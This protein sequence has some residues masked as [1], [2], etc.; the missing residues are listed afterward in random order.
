M[1]S[2]LRPL[3][4]EQ[5]F[6][7]DGAAADAAHTASAA[8]AHDSGPLLLPQAVE[9][10]TAPAARDGGKKEVVLVDTSLANYK[11]LEAG[12]RDGVG[13]VEFDGRADGLAQI[14]A[15]AAGQSG[16]DAIHILSHGNDGQLHLGSTTLTEASLSNAQVRAELTELGSALK[17]DGDVLL[18]GCD[19]AQ[20]PVGQNFIEHLSQ[21]S[22]A[23]VAASS[24]ATG[25]ALLGGDWALEYSAGTIETGTLIANDYQSL[26]ATTIFDFE[27]VLDGANGKAITQTIGSDT[28]VITAKD[29]RLLVSTENNLGFVS[30]A[31]GLLVATGEGGQ[32]PESM[33]TL[34]VSGGK[35]FDLSSFMLVPLY[36]DGSITLTTAKG[37]ETFTPTW[38]NNTWVFN[39]SNA[40]HPEYFLG[41]TSVTI[42]TPDNEGELAWAFDNIALSNISTFNTAP[43][44]SNLNGD[45]VAWAGVSNSVNLDVG[46]NAVFA[47][48]EFGAL[49][50]GNGNW[51]GASL[52]VQR[53]GTAVSADMLGFN[54]TGALF[55]VTGTTSGSLQSGGLTF[56][57]YTSIGGV[58]NIT[59]TSSGTAATTALVNDV[60]R[61]ISYRND[62]PAGDATMRYTLSDGASSTMAN[63]TVTS[64]TIYVT[65]TTDTA[66][67]NVSD[68][69]SF[70]EAVAIAAADVTGSQT[71]VFSSNFN[72]AVSLAGSLAINESLTLNADLAA[73]LTINGG[74]TITLGTGTT[75]GITNAAGAFTIAATLGGSG[76]LSKAGAGTLILSSV[77]NEA[78]MSGGITVN[79]GT[80]Q[81]S[82]DD[83]LSSGTL[84]LNGG[85][86][87][88]AASAMTIDNAIVLGAAGG[89][90]NVGGGGGSTAVVLSGVVSG[91]G[92]LTKNG[93][94]ILELS[95]NNT[96]AGATNIV[97]GTVIVSHANALG[98]TAGSTTVSGGA[99]VRLAGALTIAESFSITGSGKTVS[100]VNYGA[101]HLVSGN[102]TVSGTVTLTDAADISAASGATLTLSG[103]MS[104]AYALNKTDAGTLVLS[105]SGNEAG[106]S[107]GTTITAGTLSIAA[108]DHLSSGTITLNGGTLAITGV[109]TVDNV[110]SLPSASTISTSANATLSGTLSGANL[111]TKSGS[112]TL[113]L[114]GTNSSHFGAVNLTAG[115]L[116]LSGG[117]AL[118]NTSAV[119]LS[120]GTVLTVSN[121]ETIGSL[122]GS[123]SV[124]LNAG[125][126]VGGDNTSTTYSGVISGTSGLTKAGSGTLTL[127]GNNLYTGATTVSA[128]GLTLNRIGGAL[129][130]NTWVAIASG[131][132]LSLSADETIDALSGAGTLALGNSVLAIGI[133][134]SSS[135]FS[136]SV[137]GSGSLALDGGGTFTLS[138]ANSGQSWGVQVL[139]G[140][141]VSISGDANLGSGTLQL[142]DGTLSVTS[143]GTVDNAIMLGASAGR[144]LVDSGLS[145]S[146]S[147]AIGGFGALTKSGSGTLTLSGGGSYSGSTTVS[148]GKLV[149]TGD[150]SGT[151]AMTVASG[152]TL[153]GTGSIFATASNNTVTVRGGGVLSPGYS[154]GTLTLNG[155]LQME[156]GSTL[157]V[158]I[159]GTT[160]G[161]QYDQLAVNG[162]VGVSG[163][164]LVVSGGYTPGSG[165]SYTLINNNL[166][167]NVT[168]SFSGLAEGGTVTAGG[169]GV[170]MTASY[171]GGTGNDFVLTAPV[172][173][174]PVL[175]NLNGDSVVFIEGA[176]AVLLDSG[177]DATV[178][179]NT[180]VDFNSGN[181]TVAIV[182]N[183]VNGEDILA[184]VNQG[185]GA[186]QI[187]VSGLNITFGGQVIGSFTGGAG[188]NDLV[189]SLNANATP[190]AVQ[191]LVRNISYTN[192]NTADPSTA[193]RTVR[194]TVNDGDGATSGNADITVNVTD[195]ND[196][197]IL[198]S[199]GSSPTYT[200]NGSAVQLYSGTSISTVEVGQSIKQIGVEVNNLANGSF[201][202][203]VIDGTD[204]TLTNGFIATTGSNGLSVSVTVSGSVANV[205]ISHTSIS[206][207]LAQSIVNSLAY[208]NDSDSPSGGSRTVKLTS[209]RDSGGTANAGVDATNVAISSAITLVAVNDAPTLSGGPFFLTGTNEDT[210]STGTQINTVLAGLNYSDPDSGALL[211]AAVTA[212][213]GN[214]TWQFSLNGVSGWTAFGTVSN[215][216]ALL[217]TGN[218]YVRYVPDGANGETATLTLRAW[219]QTSGTASSF[220]N[221]R[222][223]DTSIAGG[224]SA[225]S[226][227]TAAASITVTNANDAPVLTAGSPTLPGLTDSQIN[228][229]GVLVSQLYSTNYTDVDNSASKGIAITSLNA[230]NGT[231]QYSLDGSNWYNVGVVS[232]N[233]ALLLRSTDHVRFVPNGVSGTTASFTFRAWDQTGITNGMHGTK[234]VASSAGGITP[235]SVGL[236][237]ASIT[238]TAVNDA[239]TLTGSV[240]NL[241]WNEGNNTTS[242]PV[243]VDSG[244]IITDADGPYIAS[245]TARISNNYSNGNDYLELVSNPATMG[246][247]TGTWDAVNG[248][249]TLTS[250]GNQASLAQF[251]AALRAVT[252]TN[253]SD[254]P[255]LQTRTVQFRVN[256]GSLDS[257]GV[258]RDI[259]M[260]QVD[261]T[262]VIS[263]PASTQ[264]VE[265]VAS[266][267][268]QISISDPDSVNI[269][270]TLSVT[271]GTLSAT[272]GAG[273]VVGGNATT[274]NVSGTIVAVNAF[275][276]N[277]RLTYTTAANATADATLTV[278]VDTGSAG[279]DTKT[280]TLSVTPVNDAPVVTVPVSLTVTEDVPGGVTNISFSD[281]DAGNA[282]VTATFSVTSGVLRA[283]SG[284]GVTVDGSG[285]GTLTLSGSLSDINTFIAAT[286]VS[287]QTAL[288]STDSVL[289]TVSINDNGNT[290]GAA[291]TDSKT[292]IINVTAVNDAPVN[293]VPGAQST[294]QNEV[295]AFNTLKGNA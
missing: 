130:D 55:T 259:N 195:V 98:N 293:S 166:N 260:T 221:P 196:A 163:A 132:T 289:L 183:R 68:G 144:I 175:G 147:G 119:T 228:D 268:N 97:T 214:G 120:S 202:K 217:L 180:S 193:T 179:D 128:G 292:V 190:A 226:S 51:S 86:L 148:A 152:A 149:V 223:G 167:D 4:L 244:V 48:T 265:D 105:N 81:V 117:S 23:D 235:F 164:I 93:Q 75:L 12:V 10:R 158:E 116:T 146:L 208:R 264:V 8:V 41:V 108:D 218:T 200:E 225:Y 115:G 5:R 234:A 126:T 91:S 154:V 80:L 31:A 49:N 250:A 216:T 272:S 140:G 110:I 26:L 67:I 72:S 233:S 266:V 150:L 209:I 254:S 50:G 240:G 194:I 28:L 273:V 42:T 206:V 205:T 16:L 2:S 69:V 270:M 73:G 6:M 155:N 212:T 199:T 282:S 74:S 162:T 245:A 66:T 82:S 237:T 232:L 60:A 24:D 275:I 101:L 263:A 129:D 21:V 185:G 53:S 156:V 127:T 286:R 246:N 188:S 257:A 96:Y 79:G 36:L 278:L 220:A 118:G 58:M 20:T 170:V 47:D 267:I 83:H 211:G 281:V 252:F 145:V 276:A 7:F 210:T 295:L 261:D 253:L 29:A 284:S 203:L 103:V 143:S 141:T 153:A 201:E 184:I 64:D 159:N 40:A 71:L 11:T 52:T 139:S 104:G 288:N 290:G 262:P 182:A 255:T 230:G 106:L 215:S 27:N 227:G 207:A 189:I 168:G 229:T 90:I 173:D 251:Q 44:I 100:A 222:T 142:N 277:N 171:V 172:N 99:T 95:G 169:N 18:Y 87:T 46:G 14:A 32:S 15:W 111:L 174:A 177:N 84:T 256:D 30:D 109:T 248:T 178:V 224:S 37:S 198:T 269:Y 125:L 25:S 157:A 70:S 249:L 78:N 102:S 160:A 22:G 219:D 287:F 213:T 192:S 181:V 137:T 280:I 59:F 285:T 121:A 39:V 33:L 176:S 107:A 131:A 283:V 113:T 134:G 45:S 242:I 204:I 85:T 1:V 63:V 291:Q 65:N 35:S 34:T 186:G 247:I 231:W 122:A 271:S 92:T 38:V 161:S 274:M 89:T 112:G 76:A 94:A 114:S 243:V 61:H 19:L 13:I 138:G 9:V 258:T 56:A 43:V 191:A 238:V 123:G 151:S 135:T 165:D 241:T 136:G 62:T 279:T 77:S 236:D 54:T 187:G 3:A 88:N 57:T 133:N 17:P 197:P 239:P 124:V 294:K